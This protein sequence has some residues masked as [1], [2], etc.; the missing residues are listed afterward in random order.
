MSSFFI[1]LVSTLCVAPIHLIDVVGRFFRMV[2]TD[3][4]AVIAACPAIV[5]VG[6]VWTLRFVPFL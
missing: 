4:V 3:V 6:S 2:G 5:A 1:G